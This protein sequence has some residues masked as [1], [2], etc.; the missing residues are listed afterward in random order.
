MGGGAGGAADSA[1]GE[2]APCKQRVAKRKAV[3]PRL[4]VAAW[5]VIEFLAPEL[6]N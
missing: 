1:A 2:E 3:A 5:V 4:E 6:M